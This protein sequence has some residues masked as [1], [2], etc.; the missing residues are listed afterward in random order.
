[1]T[2]LINLL[3]WMPGYSGFGSYV[4]RVI[5]GVEGTCLQ[6]N[7][8]G[9]PVL[10]PSVHCQITTPGL[11]SGRRMRFLQSNRLLQHGL[12]LDG[13]LLAN[14]CDFREFEAIYSP[15]FDALLSRQQLPQLI[16][17]HDLTPL[18]QPNSR[19]AWLRYRF[20][21]PRHVRAATRLI[22]ISRYVADQLI[23]FGASPDRVVVIPNG[24][25]I[26]RPRVKAPASD[27]LLVLAR[28]DRNKNL[29]GFL[30]CLAG[31]QARLPRWRGTVLIVGRS[32]GRQT[33]LIRRA[34]Q[35]LPRPWQVQLVERLSS[36][37]LIKSLR[38]SLALVSASVEEGF[39]YPVLEAKAEGIPTL[40]SD[41]PVHREFHSQSSLLFPPNDDG[42]I[43]AGELSHLLN[44]QFCWN[45]LSEA[46]VCLAQSMT[47]AK[48]QQSIRS[49][50]IS[51]HR[52]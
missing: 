25:T 34:I 41:I 11:A 48:Q 20:W 12:D 19:K 16:T 26:A 40:V 27:N 18:V 21:Q 51:L 46:G 17:C 9:A 29:P 52:S 28:H 44:D 4:Q 13:V 10:L 43:F 32:G 35:G 38:G 31:V 3:S 23:A 5:P 30:R 42:G 7:Q 36:Q 47:V 22:A 8:V 2:T 33:A 6:L 24:I 14:G 1:M 49:E 37:E 45:Q 15:F 50:I 39:D